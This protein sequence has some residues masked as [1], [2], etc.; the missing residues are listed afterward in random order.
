MMRLLIFLTVFLSIF[1]ANTNFFHKW[2]IFMVSNDKLYQ[3][4]GNSK[5]YVSVFYE[6]KR[7][8]L[9][10]KFKLKKDN[11]LHKAFVIN[12]ISRE[13]KIVLINSE[14]KLQNTNKVY[15]G[16]YSI[17]DMSSNGEMQIGEDYRTS[18][19]FCLSMQEEVITVD[20][21]ET[22]QAL[23][24]KDDEYVIYQK[25][26]DIY[27]YN[28]ETREKEYLFKVEEYLKFGDI[29]K[30]SK[31]ILCTNFQDL[32][33]LNLENQKLEIIRHFEPHIFQ[34]RSIV[35][36]TILVL[37]GQIQWLPDESGI[38]YTKYTLEQYLTSLYGNFG[39]ESYAKPDLFW[40]DLKTGKDEYVMSGASK[41][42]FGVR[43][44][45]PEK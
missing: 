39:Q 18:G 22:F 14:G 24:T 34:Y 3:I 45:V 21:G 36:G 44:K 29:S 37:Q 13:R 4:K 27:R 40:Y 5:E 25:G 1:F 9:R 26:L 43:R 41:W 35:D 6:D 33:I 17:L 12:N 42:G 8:D 19:V 31:R 20:E 38:V 15:E 28:I 32:M 16:I 23:F 2:D 7:V 11:F 10:G 30:D